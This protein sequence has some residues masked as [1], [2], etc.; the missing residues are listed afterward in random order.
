MHISRISVHGLCFIRARRS[1]IKPHPQ[2][3]SLRET[4]RDR[5]WIWVSLTSLTLV[6]CQMPLCLEAV[7]HV[8]LLTGLSTIDVCRKNWSTHLDKD[9]PE[10]YHVHSTNRIS[11][12]RGQHDFLTPIPSKQLNGHA[13][14][15]I[16]I[17]R[18][19]VREVLRRECSTT[20][21]RKSVKKS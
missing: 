20:Q 18:L 12:R 7:V 9:S 17:L 10:G 2:R 13:I 3:H 21:Y 4:R 15:R 11:F 14:S 1:S 5:I 19:Y 6:V 8:C 16:Y